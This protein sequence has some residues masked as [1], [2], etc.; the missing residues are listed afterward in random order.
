MIVLQ[1]LAPQG[2]RVLGMGQGLF[3]F[4]FVGIICLFI[5]LIGRCAKDPATRMIVSCVVPTVIFGLPLLIVLIS[6]RADPYDKVK[7]T[8]EY[9]T[10]YL[11]RGA[12]GTF[13]I[14]MVLVA[15]V[16]Y[17]STH[18]C[19]SVNSSRVENDIENFDPATHVY[20]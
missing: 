11:P 20:K 14:L 17:L 5:I 16:S 7:L 19:K 1:Q 15:F 4:I 6:P 12:I 3:G 10:T 18:A 9:D 8:Q 2:V 13:Q